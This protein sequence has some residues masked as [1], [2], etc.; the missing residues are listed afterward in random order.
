MKILHTPLIDENQFYLDY[1]TI[2]WQVHHTIG[3]PTSI[4]YSTKW[5]WLLKKDLDN[6]LKPM[7]KTWQN[8]SGITTI[9]DGI[10]KNFQIAFTGKFFVHNKQIFDDQLN[11]FSSTQNIKEDSESVQKWFAFFNDYIITHYN[12]FNEGFSHCDKCQNCKKLKICKYAKPWYRISEHGPTHTI[13][14]VDVATHIPTRFGKKLYTYKEFKYP[15]S[16]GKN[17][18]DLTVPNILDNGELTAIKRSLPTPLGGLRRDVGVF[19]RAYDKNYTESIENLKSMV[20]RFGIDENHIRKEWEL[21][22]EFLKSKTINIF[23]ITD[24]CNVLQNKTSAINLIIAMRKNKDIILSKDTKEY[25]ALH[26]ININKTMHKKYGLSLTLKEWSKLHTTK[27][28]CYLS[29]QPKKDWVSRTWKPF[30]IMKPALIHHSDKLSDSELKQLEYLVYKI[31]I[32]RATDN[33]KITNKDIR[34]LEIER[35]NMLKSLL[36]YKVHQKIKLND[37][38][39]FN[40]IKK[41]LNLTSVKS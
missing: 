32:K 14:R 26:D 27:Y 39:D 11:T 31:Q 28:H 24:L 1:V 6:H 22:G 29:K 16:I 37:L 35:S 5:L 2:N 41:G 21:K 13:T 10:H 19:L 36:N 4:S 23:T 3:S 25:K 17:K 9:V 20:D 8:L 34:Q 33:P 15:H 40:L 38:E 7:V 18:K 12:S 30:S